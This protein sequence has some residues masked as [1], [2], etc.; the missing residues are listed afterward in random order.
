M[1]TV[2]YLLPLSSKEYEL[3]LEHELRRTVVDQI[4]EAEPT[5]I[6]GVLLIS[7]SGLSV[8]EIADRLGRPAGLVGWSVEKLEE[9]G[10]CV[11]IRDDDGSSTVR[12]FAPFSVR[13]D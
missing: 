9:D 13:N 10:L 8:G 3:D 11:R 6:L 5:T 7:K 4:R 2:D 1:E 12:L